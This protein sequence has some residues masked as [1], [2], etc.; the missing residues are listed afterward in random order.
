MKQAF[1]TG[2]IIAMGLLVVYQ[3]YMLWW[4]KRTVGAIPRAIIILRGI[5]IVVLVGGL[6]LIAVQLGRG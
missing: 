2:L 5:N 6:V 4:T 1:G 3:G